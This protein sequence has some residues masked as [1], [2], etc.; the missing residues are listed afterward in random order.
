MSRNKKILKTVFAVFCMIS[1]LFVSGSHT[2]TVSA[3]SGYEFV[4]LDRYAKT[5]K[6]GD[7]FYLLAITS[8]GKKPSFSSSSSSVASVNTYGKVTAK[9]AGTA[10]ITAKIKNGEASCKITVQKT[11]ITL[12]AKSISLENG[13]LAKLKATSSTGHPITYKYITSSYFHDQIQ[14]IQRRFRRRKRP[15]YRQKAWNGNHYGYCG[16]IVRNL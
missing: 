1:M 13:A 12:S 16:Q 3:A 4:V 11:S 7:E 15:D 6:I 5:M 14:Q 2:N 10:T 8:T 9:K